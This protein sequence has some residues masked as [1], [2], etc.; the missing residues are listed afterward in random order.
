M[1]NQTEDLIIMADGTNC[2]RGDLARA[3]DGVLRNKN[4]VHAAL[5]SD[6]EP[7]TVKKAAVE[8][9]NVEAADAGRRTETS[10]DDRAAA[11]SVSE[12]PT[13]RLSAPPRDPQAPTP[14]E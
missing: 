10:T 4:G 8:N 14:K 7:L 12:R 6:G 11:G 1:T 9:K 3:D 2:V 5:G 13:E